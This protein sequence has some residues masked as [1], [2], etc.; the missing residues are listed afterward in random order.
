MPRTET[1]DYPIGFRLGWSDWQKDIS[2]VCR[3]AKESGF[4]FL[5]VPMEDVGI[6][7]QVLASGL[8]VG[9]FDLPRPWDLFAAPDPGRRKAMVEKAAGLIRSCTA[10]GV[11]TFFAV[12]F[13]DD[14]ARN[15]SESL[16]LAA[17]GFGELFNAI[18]DTNAKIALEGWPGSPP[19]YS[20]LACT[21]ESIRALFAAVGSPMMGIN[22]DPSHLIRMG[23]DPV[24]FVS[25]FA[26]RIWHVHAKETEISAEALYQFGNLQSATLTAP[27]GYGG[28]HWRYTIPGHGNAP[29]PMLMRTLKKAGYAGG[30]SVELEDE[31][32]NGT[33]AGEKRGLI[34]SLAFPTGA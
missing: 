11:K 8:K 18:A 30:I 29:W 31:H 19:H 20:A 7:R 27:H 22:F 2:A 1:G 24:R 9:T 6:V 25:E 26:D 21:P 28:H 23:I 5:D 15:R 14:P 33:E 32:Y 12:A 17:A 4:E 3:F 34:E 10:L 13:P 16:K